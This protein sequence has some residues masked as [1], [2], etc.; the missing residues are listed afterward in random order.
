MRIQKEILLQFD[1]ICCTCS[2]SVSAVLEDI[3]LALVL[4]DEA[5][6]ATEAETTMAI[7]RGAEALIQVGDE[8]QRQATVSDTAKKRAGHF[9]VRANRA[10][11]R[12][13]QGAH[14]R[15]YTYHRARYELP[16]TP[17]DLLTILQSSI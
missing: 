15:S 6:Q 7:A 16:T 4:T 17:G 12:E 14:W 10:G 5:A 8:A 9:I 2:S 13:I 3:Q 1:V 11:W